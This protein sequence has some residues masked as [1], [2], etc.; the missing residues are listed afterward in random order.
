MVLQKYLIIF[1][2]IDIL[3]ALV[4]KR[5]SIIL[6]FVNIFVSKFNWYENKF[7]GKLKEDTLHPQNYFKED[8]VGK[9][10]HALIMDFVVNI[11]SVKIKALKI[12]ERDCIWLILPLDDDQKT[13][14]FLCSIVHVTSNVI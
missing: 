4:W 3:R 5:P 6:L 9:V 2:L 12:L 11:F 13:A 10:S 7:S 1:L 14:P 8:L